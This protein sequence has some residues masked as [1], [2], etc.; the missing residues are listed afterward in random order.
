MASVAQ[1]HAKVERSEKVLGV[2]MG[3]LVRP[4]ET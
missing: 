4:A 1:T 3:Y 2:D